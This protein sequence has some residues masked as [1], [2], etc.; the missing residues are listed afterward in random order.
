[1]LGHSVGNHKSALQQLAQREHGAAPVYRLV[2]ESGPDHSKMFQIAAEIKNRKFTPA[3]GRTK[4]DAEQRAAGNALAEIANNPP[5][6]R[7]L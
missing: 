7:D 5:P 3:W 6:F 2:T 1:M 4:K